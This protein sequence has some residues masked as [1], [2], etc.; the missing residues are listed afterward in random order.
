[1]TTT[2]IPEHMD[3]NL[4]ALRAEIEQKTGRTPEEL[5]EEREKRIRDAIELKEPDRVP[6]FMQI[7][8]QRFGSPPKEAGRRATLYFEPD[9]CMGTGFLSPGAAWETLDVKNR[10]WPGHGL[11]EDAFGQ[12]AIEGEYMKAD[13]YDLFLKDPADFSIRRYLPRIY[14]ALQ[15]LS[16]LPSLSMLYSSGVEGIAALCATPEFEQMAKTLSKAG[17]E[18][19][20]SRAASGN[21]QEDL[22]L[23]GFPAFSHPGAVPR[24]APFDVISAH[25]RG[26]T[27]SMLDMF[28]R[29]EKLLKACEMIAEMQIA[30]SLP[31]DPTKRGNPKRAAMPLWRG[32]KMFMSQKQFETFYWP[33]LKK[34]MLATIELGYVPMPFFEAEFGDRLECLLDLPKGKVIASVEHMDVV[35]AKEILGGHCCVMGKG[36]HSLRY[37]SLKEVGEYYQNMVKVCGKGGGFILWMMLPGKGNLE[38]IKAMV[39]SVKEAGRF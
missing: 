16:R 37:C 36:P 35:R 26:M 33:G 14:G 22:A 15:P 9:M 6:M 2:A 8:S 19:K 32:D 38:D 12:Q 21:S 13:E 3:D 29:P 10:V 28:Q 25:L 27:G 23:L 17:V 1:M 39:D 31:A 5:Y 4:R 11:P 7:P 30:N 18:L 24:G 20:K 34:V